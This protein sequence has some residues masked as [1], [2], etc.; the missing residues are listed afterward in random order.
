MI[1]FTM[2]SD[3]QLNDYYYSLRKKVEFLIANEIEL[4]PNEKLINRIAAKIDESRE[5]EEVKEEF[6]SFL[7]EYIRRELRHLSIVYYCYCKKAGFWFEFG[8]ERVFVSFCRNLMGVN[9]FKEVTD[10]NAY[11][12]LEIIRFEQNKL[13]L[14][15]ADE[16][17]KYFNEYEFDFF[18]SRIKSASLKILNKDFERLGFTYKI[19]SREEYGLVSFLFYKP[20]SSDGRIEVAGKEIVRTPSYVLSMASLGDLIRREAIEVICKNKWFDEEPLSDI[21]S[22]RRDVN[23]S[24]RLSLMRQVKKLYSLNNKKREE[25]KTI[26]TRDVIKGVQWFINGR[27][28]KSNIISAVFKNIRAAHVD[29]FKD[30]HKW[31]RDSILEVLDYALIDWASDDIRAG[32]VYNVINLSKVDRSKAEKMF[33]TYLSDNWFVDNDEEYMRNQNDILHGL[34]VKYINEDATINFE[35]LEVE[36]FSLLDFLKQA[37]SEF[38]NDFQEFLNRPVYR[39]KDRLM[40]FSHITSELF[41]KYGKYTSIADMEK[42]RE[43]WDDIFDYLK[44]SAPSYYYN[45]NEM[46]ENICEQFRIKLLNFV[47]EGNG[48][49]YNNNLRNYIVHRYTEVGICKIIEQDEIIK[50]LDQYFKYREGILSLPEQKSVKSQFEDILSGKANYDYNI[51]YDNEPDPFII[52]IQYLL[53]DTGLGDID[54]P[55][56]IMISNESDES[57]YQQDDIKSELESLCEYIDEGIFPEFISWLRINRLYYEDVKQLLKKIFLSGGD[58]LSTK[59]KKITKENFEGESLLYELYMDTRIGYM[60]W[61]TGQAI[62]RI[63][64]DLRPFEFLTYYTIDNIFLEYLLDSVSEVMKI[65]NRRII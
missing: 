61:K 64:F 36:Y 33:W 65:K 29:V 25:Q 37:V 40:R 46:I 32:F 23:I 35:M 10:F 9:N 49:K 31:D 16:Y 14:T 58:P 20:E 63:N 47:T 3:E 42:N 51:C 45:M 15:N 62:L 54:L 6:Y 18:G 5:P 44:K 1:N 11:K 38:E 22:S 26:I 21:T 55:E 57:L 52:L 17:K 43:F 53:I 4:P 59:I 8:E 28:A 48:E 19:E 30:E 50:V 24:I 56:R 41:Q 39:T 2:F 60:D 12:M 27:Y 34:L 7:L 13:G